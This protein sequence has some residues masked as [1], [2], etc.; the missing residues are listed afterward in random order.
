M[1]LFN[2]SRCDRTEDSSFNF[3]FVRLVFC[4]KLVLLQ[5][6]P[7]MHLLFL[8]IVAFKGKTKPILVYTSAVQVLEIY[9]IHVP[10]KE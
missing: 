4:K 8:Q 5:N 10:A 6:F 9:F 1:C 3:I 7:Q 2:R